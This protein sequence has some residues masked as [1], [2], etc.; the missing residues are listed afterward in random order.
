MT[1]S[2]CPTL[3]LVGFPFPPFVPE[4]VVVGLLEAAGETGR[5]LLLFRLLAPARIVG[6]ASRP[7]AY[8]SLSLCL[9]FLL[10]VE[11]PASAVEAVVVPWAVAG[12]LK[13]E[14]KT[15][16]E[17]MGACSENLEGVYVDI[18]FGAR[19]R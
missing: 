12:R 8:R 18:D 6:G 4:V 7:L 2:A 9:T 16:F 15:K 17:L 14:G 3:L 1:L 13:V 11:G 10:E 19:A 5:F